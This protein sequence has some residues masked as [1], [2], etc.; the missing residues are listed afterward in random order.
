MKKIKNCSVVFDPIGGSRCVIPADSIYSVQFEN[1]EDEV[2]TSYMEL[3]D[4]D[5]C[6]KGQ[7][8]ADMYHGKGGGNF[9]LGL[10]F[11][12]FGVIGAALGKP[13]P[14]SGSK[15]G[16]MS[17]NKDLFQDPAYLSCY[18]KKA[19]GKAVGNA[20]LGWGA[21]VLLVIAFV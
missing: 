19:R 15:T 2:Y 1:V 3:S 12:P 13:A 20:A 14:M 16:F 9:C 8:D 17:Q 18:T 21:W 4:M 5:K 7:N 10:L 11:G 6:L